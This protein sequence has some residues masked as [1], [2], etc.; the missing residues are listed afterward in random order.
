MM[1]AAVIGGNPSSAGNPYGPPVGD[2]I[3]SSEELPPY[4]TVYFTDISTGFPTAWE[5]RINGVTFANTKNASY[6][7]TSEGF[8]AITLIVTNAYGLGSHTIPINVTNV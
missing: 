2:F 3:A 8:Y 4:N 7:F 5:W 6:Y 1:V